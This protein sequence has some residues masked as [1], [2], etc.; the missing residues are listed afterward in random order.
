MRFKSGLELIDREGDSRVVRKF[1]WYPR[2]FGIDEIRLFEF[3]RIR[4]RVQQI[5][6]GYTSIIPH[7]TGKYV[8]DWV[9][10]GFAD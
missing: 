6:I 5:D 9:E 7:I 2:Q 8:Y 10:Y 3:A 4:E 1:L